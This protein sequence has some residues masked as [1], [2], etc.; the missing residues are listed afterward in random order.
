MEEGRFGLVY[1]KDGYVYPA[2]TQSEEFR[3]IV[4]TMVK[5]GSFGDKIIVDKSQV[6]GKIKE[7]EKDS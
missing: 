4:D 3:G 6:L 7:S 5:M 2:Y 1:I